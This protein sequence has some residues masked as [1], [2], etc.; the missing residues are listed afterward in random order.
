MRGTHEAIRGVKPRAFSGRT[1]AK[2]HETV[3]GLFV[4]E[5]TRF[6][7]NLPNGRFL[8][9]VGSLIG[10]CSVGKSY[11][12]RGLQGFPGFYPEISNVF[13]FKRNAPRRRNIPKGSSDGNVTIGVLGLTFRHLY[14]KMVK[15]EGHSGNWKGAKVED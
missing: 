13:F 5:S 14:R 15:C 10:H 11:L 6:R 2:A 12:N 8:L 1:S 3:K 7:G 4:A 9:Y